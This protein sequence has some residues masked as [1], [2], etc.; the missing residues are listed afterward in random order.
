MTTSNR[1]ILGLARV[2]PGDRIEAWEHR[3]PC[4]TG[5]VSEVAPQLGIAWVLE[6]RTGLRRLVS[7]RNHRL[8]RSELMTAA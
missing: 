3:Q 1:W 4:F 2:R 7:I 5:T 6:D 8:R